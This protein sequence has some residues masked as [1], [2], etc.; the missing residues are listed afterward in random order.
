[1]EVRGPELDQLRAYATD[2]AQ[3]LA[4]IE[5]TVDVSDGQE[6]TVPEVT[7]TVDKEKAIANNLTVAQIYQHV[8][9]LV[10]DGVEV[11][12][13]TAD[14]KSWLSV[15]NENQPDPKNWRTRPSR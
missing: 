1:M 15:D 3:K 11:S 4:Q 12:T 6:E 13:M 9:M 14:G 5:G 7:L 8:A 10:S 2:I